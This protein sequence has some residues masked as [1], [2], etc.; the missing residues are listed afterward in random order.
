MVSPA[1]DDANAN[2]CADG[3]G[4]T[5]VMTD[6]IIVVMMVVMARMKGLKRRYWQFALG[7][8]RPNTLFIPWPS[9]S[10]AF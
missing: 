4:Q 8:S 10:K 6:T 7:Q 9:S 3:E 5:M 1:D 2:D